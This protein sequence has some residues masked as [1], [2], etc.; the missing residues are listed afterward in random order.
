MSLKSEDLIPTPNLNF[1]YPFQQILIL[2]LK[3]SMGLSTFLNLQARK[4]Y[5]VSPKE[6]QGRVHHWKERQVLD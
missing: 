3:L 6:L 5:Y 2:L 1:L 4:K